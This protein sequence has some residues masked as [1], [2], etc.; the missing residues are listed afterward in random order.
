[1]RARFAGK[2][3]STAD[4]LRAMEEEMPDSLK[5]EGGKSLQWFY[6]SW[7]NGMAIP[8]LEL[9]EVKIVKHAGSAVVT[10][11]ILQ[12]DSPDELVTAVPVYASVGG[13]Q[14]PLGYVFADGQET[15][16]RLHAPE[17]AK[18]VVLDPYGTVLRRD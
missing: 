10:G 17:G 13:R 3:M 16:F 7:V 12:K 14:A 18:N 4:F 2:E 8:K 11:K 15:R 9:K 6:E 5:Y 1:L